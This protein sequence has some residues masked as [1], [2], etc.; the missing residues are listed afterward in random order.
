MIKPNRAVFPNT[1]V[2]QGGGLHLANIHGRLCHCGAAEF[3]GARL[4]LP[5]TLL[6]RSLEPVLLEHPLILAGNGTGRIPGRLFN[7][8]GLDFGPFFGHI[9]PIFGRYWANFP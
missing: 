2:V 1:E 6:S 8:L 7:G 5:R 3:Q 4:G 9:L